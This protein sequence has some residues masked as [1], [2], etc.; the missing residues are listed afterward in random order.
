MP[1]IDSG[2]LCKTHCLALRG[3]QMTC[4]DDLARRVK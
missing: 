2:A 4:K 1:H 3:K